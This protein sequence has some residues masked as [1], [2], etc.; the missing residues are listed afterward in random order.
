MKIEEGK[1]KGLNMHPNKA[2]NIEMYDSPLYILECDNWSLVEGRLMV[3]NLVYDNN[4]YN[5][6]PIDELLILDIDLSKV[7]YLN[8]RD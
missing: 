8:G 1:Y 4:I 6:K 5:S 7:K 3:H 2:L